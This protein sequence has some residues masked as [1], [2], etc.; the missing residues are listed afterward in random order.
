MLLL[1]CALAKYPLEFRRRRNALRATCVKGSPAAKVDRLRTLSSVYFLSPE[2]SSEPK[3]NGGPLSIVMLR[4]AVRV[5][6][7]IDA[8]LSMSFAAA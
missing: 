5:S 7:S 6:G 4:S 8:S 1:A 3:R 2:T